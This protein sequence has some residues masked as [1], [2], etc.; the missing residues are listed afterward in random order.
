L[1]IV[2]QRLAALEEQKEDSHKRL[3]EV[4]QLK[5]EKGKRIKKCEDDIAELKEAMPKKKKLLPKPKAAARGSA[6]DH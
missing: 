1:E 3:R 6:G 2:K 5:Q 4:E